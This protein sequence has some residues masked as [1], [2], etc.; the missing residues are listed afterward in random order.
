MST[1]VIPVLL[2]HSVNDR[3]GAF[4][5]VVS[6]REFARHVDLIWSSGRQPITISTLAAGLRGERRRLL[7]ERNAPC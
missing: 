1:V 6:R 3:P 4:W 7:R 5:G 2:Y